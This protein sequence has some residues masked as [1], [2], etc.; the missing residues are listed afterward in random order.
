MTLAFDGSFSGESGGEPR[1]IASPDINTEDFSAAVDFLGLQNFV[2]RDEIG[3]LGICG[4]GGFALNAA[5][6]DTRVKAV[7]TSTMYDMTRVMANGYEIR[8]DPNGQYDR[9]APM[10]DVEGRYKAKQA[11]NLQ[12]WADAESGTTAH[13][14]AEEH[15]PPPA[16]HNAQT[17]TTT[18][19]RAVTI[20]GR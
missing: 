17:P 9:T 3:I 16:S 18:R 20:P 12:R 14:A 19:P 1:N 13:T 4:W 2:N 10:M 8:M 5:I 7:A 15:L 6:S 11:M